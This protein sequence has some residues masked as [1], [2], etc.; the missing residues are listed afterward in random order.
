L[1]RYI[2]KG[3]PPEGGGLPRRVIIELCPQTED[4]VCIAGHIKAISQ[5]IF[6]ELGEWPTW[7][8]KVPYKPEPPVP[9]APEPGPGPTPEPVPAPPNPWLK[10]NWGWVALGILVISALLIL[11]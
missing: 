6:D 7:Y 4:A 2:V 9:P 10:D 11:L 8:G 1:T 5:G 3:Y